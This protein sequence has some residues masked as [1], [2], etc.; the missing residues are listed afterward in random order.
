MIGAALGLELRALLRSPLRLL[1]VLLVLG[2]GV[3][4]IAQ[5]RQDVR[6]WL[7]TIEAGHELQ[8]E[9]LTEAREHFAEGRQGPEDRPWVDL[10]QPRWQDWYAARRLA[11]TPAPLA[12]MA[13]ASAEAGAVTVRVNRFAN[14][15]LAQGSK[16]E[17]PGLAAAGGLDLVTVLTLLLP[18]MILALGIDVGGYERS[19]GILPLIQVQSGRD[20]SW[21][22]ARCVAIGLLAAATGLFLGALTCVAGDA[23]AADFL[24][25]AL[26]VLAYVAV[27][28]GLLAAVAVVA[29]HPSQGAVAMGSAWIVL[30]VLVPAI[31]VERSAALAAD[32]F[33][34]DLT[35]E[36]RD[37]GQELRDLEDEEI[38]A[39]LFAR[40]PHL[41]GQVPDD[42]ESDGTRAARD[43]LRLIA[44]EQRV[45]QRERLGQAQGRC[46]S[47]LSIA[48]PAVAMTHA[49]ERLAG[50]GPEAVWAYRRAIV[51]AAA[52]RTERYIRAS[53]SAEPLDAEDF[54]E[55]LAATPER[56]DS[57]A[58]PG[59]EGLAFLIAW[60]AGLAAL[61]G[62]LSPRRPGPAG[63][64]ARAAPVTSLTAGATRST[65]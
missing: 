25:L 50:R 24:L 46:V 29:R 11:R 13:F 32:D 61:A 60:A 39:R 38:Y 49:L 23:G 7:Q 31:G 53:W 18:L 16:I 15:L 6:R 48:S 1:V 22:A 34:V 2:S 45:A 58:T 64:R 12:G 65:R 37:A 51:S 10:S 62:V 56:L 54:E 30:C 63:A 9:S 4:V 47:L 57:R 21:I 43:G 41:E 42:E 44:L 14:P 28:T 52:E 55:L 35:V 40:F 8:E 26:F 36:A 3:F 5:G 27:W 19:A 20:R 17:N 59:W 33:A